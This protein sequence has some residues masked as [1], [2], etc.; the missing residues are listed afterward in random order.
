[1]T[2]NPSPL[3]Y[4][5]LQ[6]MRSKPCYHLHPVARYLEDSHRHQGGSRFLTSFTCPAQAAE[7]KK[8]CLAFLLCNTVM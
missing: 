5:K 8:N 6:T 4:E 1:M 3:T 7:Q 2:D